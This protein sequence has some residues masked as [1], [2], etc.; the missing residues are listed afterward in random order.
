V[1]IFLVII[2]LIYFITPV[3]RLPEA[4]AAH[5][6]KGSGIATFIGVV[7]L[8]AGMGTLAASFLKKISS[9]NLAADPTMTDDEVDYE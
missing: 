9:G 5:T 7:T 1:G 4:L 8:L 3:E 6:S 2:A